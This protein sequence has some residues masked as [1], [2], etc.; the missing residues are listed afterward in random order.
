[1][2]SQS[3][4]RTAVLAI[5]VVVFWGVTLQPVEAAT[6]RPK[7]PVMVGQEEGFDACGSTWKVIGL[8]NGASGFLSVRTSPSAKAVELDRLRNGVF[9]AG[10]DDKSG[11]LGIVYDPTKKLD[12]GVGSPVAKLMAYNGPCR[13]G[14]VSKRF[15]TLIAG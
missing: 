8:S 13:S 7:T 11:F 5:H 12:C 3:V 10:C 9:V 6:K 1:M 14:W 15:V 4:R 2:R